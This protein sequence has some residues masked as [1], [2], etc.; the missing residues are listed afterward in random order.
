MFFILS[1]T[2]SFLLNPGNIILILLIASFIIRKQW[3]KRLRIASV[4]IFLLFGNGFLYSE[5]MR[6]WEMKAVT[7]SSLPDDGKYGI[8]L[9]GPEDTKREP[10]DRL[11]VHDGAERIMHAVDLYK[12]GK[13]KKILFTGGNS[14]LLEGAE[15]DNSQVKN[16]Y[17]LCGVP[18]EDI[19]IESRSRN[20]RQNADLTVEILTDEE[21]TQKHIL[22]NLKTRLID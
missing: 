21:K 1:K 18:A 7:I 14:K 6:A 16:Y 3:K 13:I 9:G 2:L 15:K 22:I 4:V 17:M 20:T 8:V 19:I 10:K 11:F 5:I 12:A